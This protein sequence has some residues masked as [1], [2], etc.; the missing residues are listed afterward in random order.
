[1]LKLLN[2]VKIC[3]KKKE[4]TFVYLLVAAPYEDAYCRCR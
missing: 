2:I 3:K 1:L 4:T